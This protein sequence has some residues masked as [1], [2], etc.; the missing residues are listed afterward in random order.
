MHCIRQTLV[1]VEGAPSCKRATILEEGKPPRNGETD[2]QANSLAMQR[3]FL[4]LTTSSSWTR[5][6]SM[7]R[8]R[9]LEAVEARW[10]HAGPA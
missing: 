2:E 8:G 9:R 4:S 6:R 10:L 7:R 1:A 3:I 5:I